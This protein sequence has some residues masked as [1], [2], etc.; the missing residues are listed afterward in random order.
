MQKGPETTKVNLLDVLVALQHQEHNPSP[1]QIKRIVEIGIGILNNENENDVSTFK[2]ADLNHMIAEDF[3]LDAIS[4]TAKFGLAKTLDVLLNMNS[5][6]EQSIKM[7]AIDSAVENGQVESIRVLLNHGVNINEISSI[8]IENSLDPVRTQL[9]L[10]ENNIDSQILSFDK[11]FQT[12]ALF[13]NILAV[14]T[15]LEKGVEANPLSKGIFFQIVANGFTDMLQLLIEKNYFRFN[16]NK[17]VDK[18]LALAAENQDIEMIKLLIKY[19]ANTESVIKSA[20]ESENFELISKLL[21][22]PDQLEK[23]KPHFPSILTKLT[24]YISKEAEKLHNVIA[25]LVDAGF[26]NELIHDVIQNT[27]SVTPLFQKNKFEN[28]LLTMFNQTN[29]S[30]RQGN[31]VEDRDISSQ[32]FEQLDQKP[33]NAKLG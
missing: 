10:L 7:K 15:L 16:L 2:D 18:A 5:D 9:F 1:E 6:L 26:P 33:S 8:S 29:N 31:T 25:L 19:G 3:Y 30:E 24:A 12:S 28:S 17:Q 22:I 21:S 27:S 20:A 11:V 4:L 13:G 14:K 32:A 23:L